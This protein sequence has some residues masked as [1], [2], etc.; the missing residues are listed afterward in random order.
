MEIFKEAMYECGITALIF[1]LFLMPGIITAAFDFISDR[2]LPRIRHG[3]RDMLQRREQR[4]R[5][6]EIMRNRRRDEAALRWVNEH[7][8]R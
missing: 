1:L 5:R 6:R 4:Q 7:E 3:W 8:L 2:V